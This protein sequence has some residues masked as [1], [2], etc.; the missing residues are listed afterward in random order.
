V[1][2]IVLQ[3]KHGV[4]E[5]VPGFFGPSTLL[6]P[7]VDG[8]DFENARK[9]QIDDEQLPTAKKARLSNG[10]ENEYESTPKSPMDVDDDQ[11]G[12]GNAYPSPE[13]LPSPAVITLGP[14]KGTQVD[15]VSELSTATTFLDLSD[16]V[17]SRTTVLLQCDWNPRDPTI[18]AAAGSD[19]L[20]RMWTFSRT[21]SDVD[22]DPQPGRVSPPHHNLL[23]ESALPSTT[24][25]GL[26]WSSDGH[27]VAIASEPIDDG[28]A[29]IE[30]W[31]TDGLSVSA[32]NAFESPII[33]LRWNLSNTL[34]LALS[35]ESE[36]TLITVMSPFTHQ[37][38][39][40]SLP[41]HILI[42]QPL[43]AAWTSDEEFVL[44]GGEFLQAFRCG[45]DSI[46]PVRK[47]E[48]REGHALSKITFDWPTRL[49]ATASDTGMI[50]VSF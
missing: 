31:N 16:D 32:F 6:G 28:T 43:D 10:Y 48:T 45:G 44:C 14:E 47:Y 30:M 3:E 11:N 8:G 15:K 23:D 22:A 19:A 5:P 41:R 37:S 34:L 20:A 27:C 35:P 26:A 49:L 25:T 13:Q 18:L 40:S 29:R 4:D 9:H 7:V 46:S 2:L 39:Q 12:D 24:A 38:L 42:E 21:A 1:K 17:S 50:D 33:C 36:G